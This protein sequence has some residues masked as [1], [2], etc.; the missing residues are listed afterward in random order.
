MKDWGHIKIF[1]TN[2]KVDNDGYYWVTAIDENNCHYMFITEEPVKAGEEHIMVYDIIANF[3][4]IDDR[5]DI[6]MD[7][8]DDDEDDNE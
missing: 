8:E 1:I 5:L 3:A 6:I 7:D 2:A 4:D